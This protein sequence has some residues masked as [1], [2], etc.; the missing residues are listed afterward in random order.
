MMAFVEWGMT[1]FRRAQRADALR[2][3]GAKARDERRRRHPAASQPRAPP[4]PRLGQA[5]LSVGDEPG[6]VRAFRRAVAFSPG[7][8]EYAALLERLLQRAHPQLAAP[9]SATAPAANPEARWVA[10]G[11]GPG[12]CWFELR[13]A[14]CTTALD[15]GSEL[16]P[17]CAD[18]TVEDIGAFYGQQQQF[19][20]AAVGVVAANPRRGGGTAQRSELR[21]GETLRCGGPDPGP[22]SVCERPARCRFSTLEAVLEAGFERMERSVKARCARSPQ[23]PRGGASRRPALSWRGA[24]ADVFPPGAE[25]HPD[26]GG[27]PRRRHNLAHGGAGHSARGGVAPRR[28]P[29]AG[30]GP[31]SHGAPTGACWWGGSSASRACRCGR[32]RCDP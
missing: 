20:E 8:A 15:L 14:C 4:R 21:C 25:Q 23:R 11:G 1:H 17:G 12:R 7:Q 19:L 24:R 26:L 13:S 30:R 32:C 3:C 27:R 5:L 6:A 22:G 2:A 10:Q 31:R 28:R 29:R 9:G 16:W 18:A